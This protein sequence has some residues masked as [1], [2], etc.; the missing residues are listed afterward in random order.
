AHPRLMWSYDSS[1]H[2]DLRVRSVVERTMRVG[3][4]S[5]EE[6][7]LPDLPSFATLEDNWLEGRTS[8][9][10]RDSIGDLGA[11]SS[12]EAE[13]LSVDG[14][15]ISPEQGL[16]EGEDLFGGTDSVTT[17]GLVATVAVGGGSAMV[18]G[19]KLLEEEG[20]DGEGIPELIPS[21]DDVCDRATGLGSTMEVSD[22]PVVVGGDAAEVPGDLAAG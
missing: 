9:E 19:A 5:E 7:F 21:A 14:G 6:D 3:M 22:V 10:A 12:C 20:L 8:V 2:R 18:G 17:D 15:Q 1:K 16:Q 13:M 11:V 4:G